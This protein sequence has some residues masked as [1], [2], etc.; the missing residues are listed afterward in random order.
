MRFHSG[1]AKDE[2]HISEVFILQHPKQ[3]SRE[4]WLWHLNTDGQHPNIVERQLA[5]VSS[6]DVKLSFHDVGCMPATGSRLELRCSHFLPVIRLN[7]KDVHIVH[8]MDTVVAS[9]VDYL[10]VNETTG[11]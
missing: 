11:G 7:I 9:K 2:S 8:P 1:V 3:V 6:E 5:I 10:G 4:L